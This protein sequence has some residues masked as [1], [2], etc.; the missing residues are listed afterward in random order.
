MICRLEKEE[1][2]TKAKIRGLEEQG[3][4]EELLDYDELHK[5]MARGD[6]FQ[7]FS[8]GRIKFRPTYKYEP[9]TDDFEAKK[10]RIPS[11][12]VSDLLYY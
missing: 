8:E 11:Y 10:L 2:R 4:Y 3:N 6:A 12:T 1:D 7:K 5:A 9:G